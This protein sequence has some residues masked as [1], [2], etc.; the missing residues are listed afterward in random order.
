MNNS[1]F[2]YKA[3][4]T[5]MNQ[6]TGTAKL[7]G[8]LALTTVGMVSYD[9]RFLVAL[10]ILS[11][12]LI[13]VSHIQYREYALLLKL[14]I[15]IGVLNLI[16]ITVLAPQYGAELYG[17]K[18]VLFGSGYWTITQEQLFYELNLLLKYG[19]SF[20]LSIVLL[21][22]TNPSEFASGLNKIG[23]PYK[24][25]YAVA[26]TLRY[27]PDVQSDYHTISLA[28]QARG[29]EISKKASLTKRMKGAVQIILP[30][31]FSSL[32]RI[33]TISQA[34]ELRRFGRYNKRTWYQDQKF[35]G[36]DF[37]MI[38]GTLIIVAIGILLVFQNGGRLW[39]PFN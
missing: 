15:F 11:F 31:V 4:N 6:T 30:L 38:I 32:D 5:W 26:L 2:G 8:F 37:G 13:K 35:S 21:F 3:R 39:N 28:Q 14:V 27:I 7:V 10:V 25:S 29:Y 1:L 36:R 33:D 16:M 20:P 17:S 19:F 18:H 23:V 24:V 9:T 22:T 34:M 12:I